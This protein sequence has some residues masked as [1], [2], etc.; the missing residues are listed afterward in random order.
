MTGIAIATKPVIKIDQLAP[1]PR[2][3]APTFPYFFRAGERMID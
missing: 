3:R 1:R 2:V